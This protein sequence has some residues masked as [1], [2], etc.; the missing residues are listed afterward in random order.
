[1][2]EE[3]ELTEA[4]RKARMISDQIVKFGNDVKVLVAGVTVFQSHNTADR[5]CHSQSVVIESTKT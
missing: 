1:M 2:F 4:D 3:K 5:Y